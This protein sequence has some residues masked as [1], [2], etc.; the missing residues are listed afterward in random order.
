[1]AR[2]PADA[3]RIL[4]SQE[5]LTYYPASLAPRIA[6]ET[7]AIVGDARIFITNRRQQDVCISNYFNYVATGYTG[8]FSTFMADGM[9]CME[10]TPDMAM[11]KRPECIWDLWRYRAL[12]EAWEEVF[13]QVDILPLEAWKAQPERARATLVEVLG[14]DDVELPGAKARSRASNIPWRDKLPRPLAQF[15]KR[16]PWPDWMTRRWQQDLNVELTADQHRTI[17]EV[18]GPH[19]RWLAERT[20]W[21]LRALGYPGW[22]ES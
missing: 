15:I 22:A 1:M 13:G 10:E 4:Y 16:T 18:Y 17:E 12:Y 5:K 20:G 3:E 6:E 21:D 11:R 14:Q 7:R 9:R 19:N 8:D 2:A